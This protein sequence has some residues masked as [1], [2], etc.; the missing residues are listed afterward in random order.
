MLKPLS[1]SRWSLGTAA[2][3]LNRAGFGG[4]PAEIQKLADLGLDKAVSSLIDY[5]YISD[6]TLAPEWAKPDPEDVQKMREA[7]AKSATPEERKKL[8]QEQQRLQNERMLE[9]RA[10]WLRRMA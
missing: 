5:E 3:L 7:A 2:H 8:Q 9:L 1:K 6:G 10:W 4:T